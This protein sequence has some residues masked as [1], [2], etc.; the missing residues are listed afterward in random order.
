M[1]SVGSESITEIPVY[2]LMGGFHL[3]GK[4]DAEIRTIIKR[5]KSLGVRKVAPSHCTGDRA[6]HLFR[7]EWK[8]DFLEGGLGA[9]I[10][11]PFK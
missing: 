5:L 9:V 7:E 6:I 3:A 2:L 11:V 4:S 8:D 10:E 1:L